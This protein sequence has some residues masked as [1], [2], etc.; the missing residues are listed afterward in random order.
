MGLSGLVV[1]GPS[2][3]GWD[4]YWFRERWTVLRHPSLPCQ[5]CERPNKVTLVCDNR[6]DP[7]ACFKYWATGPVEAACR[8]GL[9]RTALRLH[10]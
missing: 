5:P 10:A 6:A 9:A 1:T 4:P 7:M 3:Y 2:A 8:E